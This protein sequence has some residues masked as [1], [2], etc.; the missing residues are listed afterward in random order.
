MVGLFSSKTDATQ[1]TWST[2]IFTISVWKNILWETTEVSICHQLLFKGT[3]HFLRAQSISVTG[4][5][6]I[7]CKHIMLCDGH[8]KIHVLTFIQVVGSSK[9]THSL[10]YRWK[11]AHKE[12]TGRP[13]SINMITFVVICISKQKENPCYAKEI[14]LE[15]LSSLTF[16]T[17]TVTS[18]LSYSESWNL[19]ILPYVWK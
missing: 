18:S 17:V 7:I 11:L 16:K 10:C 1:Q 2:F 3:R 14:N 9:H 5:M 15:F 8:G 6:D 19:N 13:H 4:P 12:M